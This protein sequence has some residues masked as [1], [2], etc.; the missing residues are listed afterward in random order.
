MQ[1][2]WVKNEVVRFDPSMGIKERIK[3]SKRARKNKSGDDLISVFCCRV[4]VPWFSHTQ[5]S[6]QNRQLSRMLAFWSHSQVEH[7]SI[8]PHS[9]SSPQSKFQTGIK[10]RIPNIQLSVLF[11]INNFTI[12]RVTGPFESSQTIESS[13]WTNNYLRRP[14]QRIPQSK[15]INV[16]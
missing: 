12:S 10:K 13:N 5:L 3:E 11:L 14:V 1:R 9:G 2:D 16:I 4:V 15:K 8:T 7:R 6:T